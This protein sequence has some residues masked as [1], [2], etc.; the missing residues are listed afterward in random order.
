MTLFGAYRWIATLAFSIWIASMVIAGPLPA[1]KFNH[2]VYESIQA[3]WW[4]KQDIDQD[5]GK[6]SVVKPANASPIRHR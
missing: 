5:L 6:V 3:A 1:I 4:I 2:W